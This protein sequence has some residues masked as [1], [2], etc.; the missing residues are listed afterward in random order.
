MR[1]IAASLLCLAAAGCLPHAQV[2]LA[3]RERVERELTGARR[4][5]DVAVNVGP[6]FGDGSKLLASEQPFQEIELLEGPGGATIRPP[7]PE[8]VL[9]PGTAVRILRVELPT[10]WVI[11]RRVVTTPRH[12][13]WAWLEVAGEA[14]PVILVLPQ[15]VSK[16]EDVELK[17]D[18][19]LSTTDP[20]A[21]WRALP[22]DQRAAIARKRLVEDMGTRAVE[23]AWGHPERK[24]ID[25]PART[26]EWSWAEGRRR[27]FFHDGKLVRWEPLEPEAGAARRP[28]PRS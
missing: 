1:R 5:L 8:R 20:S 26:E 28:S 4:W 17:L 9:V 24:L 25:K 12:H 21:A 7:P 18:R 16:F 13:P 23:M 3:D 14:R 22:D 2:P 19:W 27:A 11:A 6:F 10:G 15:E